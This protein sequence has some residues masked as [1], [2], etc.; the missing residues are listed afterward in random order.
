VAKK[1]NVVEGFMKK[2]FLFVLL[3]F[4]P[5]VANAADVCFQDDFGIIYKFKK[6]A[7]PKR[8]AATIAGKFIVPKNVSGESTNQFGIL[9]GNII[10]NGDSTVYYEIHGWTQD[11][12]IVSEIDATAYKDK[13]LTT[14]EVYWANIDFYGDSYTTSNFISIDCRYVPVYYY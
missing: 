5:F 8:G 12:S 11:Q 14:K 9:Y 10:D 7:V 6:P 1:Q 2:I 3:G 4:I 13:Y